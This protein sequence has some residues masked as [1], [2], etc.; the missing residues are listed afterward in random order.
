MTNDRIYEYEIIVKVQGKFLMTIPIA[1]F[2][3]HDR[4][5]PGRE[6]VQQMAVIFTGHL[7]RV[8][9]KLEKARKH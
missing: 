4:L 8:R 6:F 3:V 7:E 2:H 1:D 5:D 9:P